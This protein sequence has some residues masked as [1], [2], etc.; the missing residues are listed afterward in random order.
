MTNTTIKA[1]ADAF[2]RTMY[3]HGLEAFPSESATRIQH[4]MD[5]AVRA[6][7]LEAGGRLRTVRTRADVRMLAANWSLRLPPM[8]L[9]EIIIQTICHSLAI[10]VE[11]ICGDSRQRRIVLAREM[12][13]HL[14]RE[15]TTLSF[16]EISQAMGRV[17]HS[18]AMTIISRVKRKLQNANPLDCDPWDPLPQ[19]VKARTYPELVKELNKKVDAAIMARAEEN[20]QHG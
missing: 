19:L 15:R 7:Y 5:L 3:G 14:I 11:E 1:G 10:S 12:S 6:M 13:V 16:P 9:A 8:V 18:A 2:C 20:T 4:A 17:G